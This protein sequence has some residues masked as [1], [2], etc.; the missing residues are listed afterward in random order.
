MLQ[1]NFDAS[2]APCLLKE[3]TK[4]FTKF[5]NIIFLH[6]SQYL[7]YRKMKSHSK[8][9]VAEYCEHF[10]IGTIPKFTIATSSIF[11]AENSDR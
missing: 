6:R 1:Y 2:R 8:G 3:E 7:D 4:K 5:T 11:F 10:S 9:N